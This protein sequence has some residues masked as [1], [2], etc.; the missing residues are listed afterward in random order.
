MGTS[1]VQQDESQEPGYTDDV[2]NLGTEGFE[3]EEGYQQVG[4][5]TEGYC[6]DDN[7]EMPEDQM[8]YSGELAVG[9][10]GYQD[11]VLDI[12]I[13]EPIDGE[14]QVSS[15]VCLLACKSLQMHKYTHT[16][17]FPFLSLLYSSDNVSFLVSVRGQSGLKIYSGEGDVGWRFW[18][19]ED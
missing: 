4:E 8:D 10:D 14:F 7:A 6:Q 12:Q 5:Y 11:E 1:Y 15:H 16:L 17:P 18:A 2:V 9:D 3:E 13:N 19:G